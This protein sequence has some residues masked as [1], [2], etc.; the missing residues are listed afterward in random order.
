MSDKASVIDLSGNA[1]GEMSLPPQFSEPLRPDLIRRAC[2]AERSLALQPKGSFLLAGMQNSAEYYGRRRGGHRTTIN[3]GRSRLPREKIPKGRLGRVLQVPQAVKGRRA[4]PPKPWKKIVEKINH[5]ERNAAIRSAISATKEISLVK[6]RGHVY[7][8]NLP[9][10]VDASFEEI[11]RVKDLK[12][13]LEKLGVEKDLERTHERRKK[14][15]G[16]AGLRKG[17]YRVPKSI[18][19]VVGEDKGIWKAARNLP[20]VDVIG[21]D[22]LSSELLAPGGEAARLTI[23]TEDALKKMED[24]KLYLD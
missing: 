23:W 18:L 14:R 17:G 15:S 20:G 5:K 21:V 7:E 13:A 12:G 9:L 3:T 6:G 22:K 24:E 11:K 2:H 1:V 10:I 19:I 4:H 8:G 16:R